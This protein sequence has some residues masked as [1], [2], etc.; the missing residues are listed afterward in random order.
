VR[1]HFSARKEKWEASSVIKNRISGFSAASQPLP[2]TGS[3][4]YVRQQRDPDT[5][6]CQAITTKLEDDNVRAAIRL[7]L[8]EDSPVVPSQQT[9]ER[10]PG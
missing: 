6:L 3:G 2:H 7:L 4:H 8:S 9:L 1:H 10:T 5:L